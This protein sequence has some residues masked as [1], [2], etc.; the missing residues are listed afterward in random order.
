MNKLGF[1]IEV[2]TRQWIS[3]ALVEVK[4]P[5]ILWHAGDRGKLQEI[6][7]W[8]SPDSFII[9]RVF[10]ENQEQDAM[11]KSADPAA[12]GRKLAD[13]I[14]NYDY[15]YATEKVNDRLLIDAWM[16]LNEAAPGPASGAFRSNPTGITQK[17]RAYDA[18]MVGFRQQLQTQKLEAVAF[19]FAAGNFTAA[20]HYLDYFQGTLQSYRYLGFHE[21][22]WPTLK[23]GPD[24]ATSALLYRTCMEG[25]RQKYGAR[26]EVI[27]TECGLARMYKYPVDPPG[28]VGWLWSG[29]ALSQDQ[30]WEALAWYNA[31]LC[32]DLYVKGACLYQ[33]GHGGRW[34]TFRH[35][36]EDNEGR[37][38]QIISR[39]AK[40]RETSAP[41][42]PVQPPVEPLPTDLAGLKQRAAALEGQLAPAAQQLAQLAQLAA[43]K[44]PLDT[45]ADQAKQAA[46]LLDA[47]TALQGRMQ[48]AQAQLAQRSGATPALR[49]RAANLQDQLAAQRDR[50]AAVAG[51]APAISQA[52]KDLQA[53]LAGLGNLPDLQQRMASLLPAVKK[54]RADLDKGVDGD[55]EIVLQNPA[56][57]ARVSQSFGQNPAVYQ[58]FGLAGHEGIDY[59]CALATSVKA[60]ADGVVFRSGATPGTYG[61][62]KNQGP[63]GIRV[64]MEHTWGSQRGYT[65]YAHLS[66]VSVKEGDHIQTGDEVGKSGNTGNSSGPHL[67]FSLILVGNRD[68]GYKS[69]LADDAWFHDPTPF[70]PSARS[71]EDW[72]EWD[73]DGLHDEEIICLPPTRPE[74]M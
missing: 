42:E 67:H 32:R 64:I 52:Q 43:Q 33:V 2:S 70:M 21:Y 23:P 61:P 22:G 36:G 46:A 37:S 40:L 53:A 16:S 58:P 28:D 62:D 4:P 65:V 68:E 51:L 10:L 72:I 63:Y 13:R 9:G 5:T 35:L 48:R 57:G 38:I 45:A 24:V 30:Y 15:G 49:Q 59:A 3:E 41:P 26:F 71:T 29:D 60:A 1:Y 31:E 66:S 20:N 17:L 50:V 7:R 55:A 44:P 74:E 18:F 34:E 12:E 47:L 27:I 14:L 25:I 56:P 6:R 39:I 54:L 19:N 69:A 11:L 73:A 8:R